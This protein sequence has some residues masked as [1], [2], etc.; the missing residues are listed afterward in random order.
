MAQDARRMV[1]H[2]RP[3][4]ADADDESPW[5]MDLRYGGTLF[6]D[7]DRTFRVVREEQEERRRGW[8]DRSPP[9]LA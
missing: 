8:D 1:A 3:V 9:A 5:A 7:V 6:A 2:G 4:P